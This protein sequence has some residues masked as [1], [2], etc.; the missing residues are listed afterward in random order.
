MRSF[1]TLLII[2]HVTT[3]QSQV[4][5][6]NNTVKAAMWGKSRRGQ[7]M[8]C[9]FSKECS[10]FPWAQVEGWKKKEW[11]VKCH[12]FPVFLTLLSPAWHWALP[13]HA[14]GRRHT[15]AHWE[16]CLQVKIHFSLFS[17]AVNSKLKQGKC[18]EET[19]QRSGS[20][21]N[22]GPTL[23]SGNGLLPLH[24]TWTFLCLCILVCLSLH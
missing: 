12:E 5:N 10:H 14:K 16:T 8:T 1:G 13:V 23:I 17:N 7:G 15:E 6:H 2:R 11:T 4:S 3:L 9:T 22:L 24:C 19:H 20:H 21:T 18:L